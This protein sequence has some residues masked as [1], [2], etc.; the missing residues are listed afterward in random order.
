MMYIPPPPLTAMRYVTSVRA[1]PTPSFM[2]PYRNRSAMCC[3]ASFSSYETGDEVVDEF[4]PAH[5][6]PLG[7][8]PHL[9]EV[10]VLGAHR[11]FPGYRTANVWQRRAHTRRL[12]QSMLGATRA[13]LRSTSST[14]GV[15][16]RDLLLR[17]ERAR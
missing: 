11:V 7:R 6:P 5:R 1:A 13:A 10:T 14:M 9:Q 17:P 2:N 12:P 3:R 8:V 15:T 4:V 16:R